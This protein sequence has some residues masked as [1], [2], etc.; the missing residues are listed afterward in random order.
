MSLVEFSDMPDIVHYFVV[1]FKLNV[2]FWWRKISIDCYIL[3]L[4][5]LYWSEILTDNL[6]IWTHLRQLHVN[7]VTVLC[8]TLPQSIWQGAS[9]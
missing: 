7:L 4:E 3:I 1:N 9:S 8:L 6:R 2:N 5:L